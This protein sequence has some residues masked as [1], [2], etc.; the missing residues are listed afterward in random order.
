MYY[1]EFDQQI[2]AKYGIV[3]E[4]WPLTSFV[5]PGNLRTLNELDI[6]F[7]AWDTGS[8]RFRKMDKEELAEWEEARFQD[9]LGSGEV[10]MSNNKC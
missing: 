5:A 6:L 2:T 9:A 1:A 7:R 8:T 3:V 4:C 10:T